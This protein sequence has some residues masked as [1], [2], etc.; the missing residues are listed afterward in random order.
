MD[1]SESTSQMLFFPGASR[2]RS[3][4]A[5]EILSPMYSAICWSRQNLTVAKHPFPSI[6]DRATPIPGAIL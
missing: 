2:L 4:S 1:H 5:K 3:A 6:L